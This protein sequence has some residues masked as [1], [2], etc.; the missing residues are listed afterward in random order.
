VYLL[1][2][3]VITCELQQ[4]T[5]A[6]NIRG[7]QCDACS[8]CVCWYGRYSNVPHAAD[9]AAGRTIGSLWFPPAVSLSCLNK[10]MTTMFNYSYSW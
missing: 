6:A 2:L 1:I 8:C 5:C 10:R 3:R 9:A 7:I 4:T